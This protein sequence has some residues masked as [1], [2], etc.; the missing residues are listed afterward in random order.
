MNKLADG[1]YSD[2]YSKGDTFLVTHYTGAH[3]VG[4][5]IAFKSIKPDTD[6]MYCSEGYQILW[7]WLVPTLK[8]KAKYSRLWRFFAWIRGVL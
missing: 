5:V 7:S 8:T 6:I 4:E 3:E 2:K 1:S